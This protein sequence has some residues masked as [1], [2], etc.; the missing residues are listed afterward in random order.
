MDGPGRMAADDFQGGIR[1]VRRMPAVVKVQNAENGDKVLIGMADGAGA[2]GGDAGK[3]ANGRPPP[4]EPIRHGLISGAGDDPDR[5]PLGQGYESPTAGGVHD[6]PNTMR[7]SG[8]HRGDEP[9]NEGLHAEKL[10]HGYSK[11]RQMGFGREFLKNVEQLR[12]GARPMH[13]DGPET[14]VD[15]PNDRHL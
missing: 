5:L 15:D 10:G 7:K 1:W 13:D 4:P 9:P 11:P 3:M 8:I 12:L 2:E 14:G 6:D